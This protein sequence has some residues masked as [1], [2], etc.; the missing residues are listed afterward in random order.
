[1]SPPVKQKVTHTLFIDD[2]KL[3]EKNKKKLKIEL[4][5]LE[6]KMSDAGLLWNAKKCKVIHLRKGVLSTEDGDITLRSGKV[7]NCLE[8]AEHYK[9]LGVPEAEQHDI[10]SLLKTM[11]KKIKQRTHVVWTS[12]L[13][14][15]N[16]VE[17]TNTFV[18][19]ILNYFMWSEKMNLNDLRQIDR[20]IRKKLTLCGAKHPLQLNELLYVARHNGGRG[21][22]SIERTYKETKIKSAI[23]LSMNK[24]PRM[25]LVKEFHKDCR[26]KQ[27]SSIFTDAVKY[28]EELGITVNFQDTSVELKT[29]EEEVECSESKELEKVKVLLKKQRYEKLRKAVDE[30]T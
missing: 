2:A 20:E 30:S 4:D 16:K 8:N 15:M 5:D 3:Y 10:A 18:N 25:K 14:D 1:M 19:S 12:P 11:T 6:Q 23:K 27:R 13:Y 17:A 9:F 28:G 24:D 21:L 26:T 22:R 29:N 7:I